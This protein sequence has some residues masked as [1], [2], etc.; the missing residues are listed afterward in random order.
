MEKK[1]QADDS[2]SLKMPIAKKLGKLM[3]TICGH[4][5][6][7]NWNNRRHLKS[8]YKTM[9]RKCIQ[10]Q[11]YFKFQE[12]LENHKSLKHAGS[13]SAGSNKT[14]R[15]KSKS[16]VKQKQHPASSKTLEVETSLT[17]KKVRARSGVRAIYTCHICYKPIEVIINGSIPDISNLILMSGSSNVNFVRT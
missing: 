9:K 6:T 7:N 11:V 4:K 17:S 14:W 1:E 13:E 15:L 8:H 10:C 2:T 12:Q 16:S 5:S 3:C